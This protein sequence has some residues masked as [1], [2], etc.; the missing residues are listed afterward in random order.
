[1]EEYTFTDFLLNKW[2]QQGKMFDSVINIFSNKEM[3][4]WD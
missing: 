4:F 2:T 3:C 1:M